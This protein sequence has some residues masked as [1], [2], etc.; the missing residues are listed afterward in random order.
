MDRN[1]LRAQLNCIPQ[2]P[3]LLPGC[4][5]RLNVDPSGE[6]EDDLVSNALKKVKLWDVVRELGGLD[7]TITSDTFSPGQKQL[8]CFAR[9]MVRKEG[10]ILILDEATSRLV[11]LPILL[12]VVS[13]I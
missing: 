4:S 7:A 2:A 11:V 12:P 8:L 6:I 9:A 1:A 13:H 10:K 3:F 5:V